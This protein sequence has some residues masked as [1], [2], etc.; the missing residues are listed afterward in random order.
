M[1]KV[2][3]LVSFLFAISYTVNAQSDNKTIDSRVIKGTIKDET[4]KAVPFASIN[5]KD[6]NGGTSKIGRAHV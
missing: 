5:I 6:E 4:G 3:I 2:A 1:N